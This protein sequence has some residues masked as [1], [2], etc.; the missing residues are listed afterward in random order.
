LPKTIA[1]FLNFRGV[2]LSM[3]D[4]GLAGPHAPRRPSPRLVGGTDFR[5]ATDHGAVELSLEE[6]EAAGAEWADLAA[7]ALEPNAFYEPGF[8]LPAARHFPPNARPRFVVVRQGGR[9]TGFFPVDDSG[10]SMGDGLL[11]LWVHKL[12]ALATPLVDR[13]E[14]A[15]AIA[16]FLDWA[17]AQTGAAGVVFSR[18]PAAGRFR[19]AL[20]E[21]A[22]ERARR[23]EPLDSFERAALLPGG[24]ADA[25]FALAA[26][27][28][29]KLGELRRLRRRLEEMGRVA[30]QISAS[31]EEVRRTTEEFLALEASG[32]KA[33]RG[34]LL[35]EPSLATFLRSA[36]RLLASE[37]RCR[38]HAL[39]LDGRPIAMGIVIESQN[40]S[41]FWKIAYDERFRSQAPGVQL[42]HALGVT[43]LVRPEVELTDSCAIPDHPMIDRV[44]PDRIAICDLAVQLRAGGE[45]HFASSCRRHLARRRLRDFAKRAANG[46]LKRKV[47]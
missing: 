7:R 23:I 39:R 27:S 43:Q 38:I 42:A 2:A 16:A 3:A 17:E 11:R 46:L 40:R 26:G 1:A 31:P 28:R 34:A 6:M 37:G 12:S 36:T 24:D 13:D 14:P 15:G 21:L 44:W 47:S 30:F 19:A 20:T 29:R 8:A 33:G 9:M 5:D 45:R 4:L 41:Y 18:L 10:A 32:W 22:E 25:K 35:S